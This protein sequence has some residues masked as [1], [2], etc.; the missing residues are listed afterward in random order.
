MNTGV[1]TQAYNL[2]DIQAQ[3]VTTV[4][5]TQ[6]TETSI[7]TA[8][9]QIATYFY[10]DLLDFYRKTNIDLERALCGTQEFAEA[11]ALFL[12]QLCADIDRLL[13]DNLITGMLLILSDPQDADGSYKVRYRAVYQV[14]RSP[15]AASARSTQ[16]ADVSRTG[17][18]LDPPRDVSNGAHFTLVVEW[19]PATA[20]ERNERIQ[21]PRYHFNWLP[22]IRAQFDESQLAPTYRFGSMTPTVGELMVTRLEAA[23]PTYLR[24]RP[25]SL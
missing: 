4:T 7:L 19:N 1:G 24:G 21:A 23:A 18:H 10:E 2:T 8:T 3:D 16:Q 9:E 12:S 6:A 22:V 5:A 14:R 11:P 20:R 13:S 25:Q 17:G 15:I